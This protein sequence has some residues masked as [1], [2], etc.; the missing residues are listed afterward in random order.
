MGPNNLLQAHSSVFLT[1]KLVFTPFLLDQE[2]KWRW[3]VLA[4]VFFYFILELYL[5]LDSLMIFLYSVI[6][7]D[8]VLIPTQ[9]W[10][11][12]SIFLVLTTVDR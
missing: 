6:F 7:F 5:R 11:S 1:A 9:L 3:Q 4:F 8:E 12:I 2:Y 10:M